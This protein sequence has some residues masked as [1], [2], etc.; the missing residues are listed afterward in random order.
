MRA[1]ACLARCEG[2]RLDLCFVEQD[3]PFAILVARDGALEPATFVMQ[4]CLTGTGPAEAYEPGGTK[5]ARAAGAAAVAAAKGVSAEVVERFARVRLAAAGC[6]AG[7]QHQA[8]QISLVIGGA[9]L[10]TEITVAGLPEQV[11]E[12]VRGMLW[13]LAVPPAPLG[14]PPVRLKL[15]VDLSSP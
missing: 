13:G 9:G 1:E 3:R 7:A 8:A 6:A 11:A 15:A 5:L 2:E 14:A 4:M 12:C 10:P